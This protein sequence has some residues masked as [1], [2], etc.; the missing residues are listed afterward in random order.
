MDEGNKSYLKASES[1]LW[2]VLES[3]AVI[4]FKGGILEK[5]LEKLCFLR[6]FEE[7]LNKRWMKG[8]KVT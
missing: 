5:Y 7:N 2:F 6:K 3:K 4:R 8:T 1:N